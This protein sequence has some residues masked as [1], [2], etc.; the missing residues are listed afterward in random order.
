MSSGI[1]CQCK[2]TGTERFFFKEVD[3]EPEVGISKARGLA[4]SV[5]GLGMALGRAEG[6]ADGVTSSVSLFFLQH[7]KDFLSQLSFAIY[8]CR[9]CDSMSLISC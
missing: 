2:H 5:L 1:W 9:L 3:A 7:E 8:L 6:Q 4:D